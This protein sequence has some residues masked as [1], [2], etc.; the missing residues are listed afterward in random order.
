MATNDKATNNLVDNV[1][2]TILRDMVDVEG[3]KALLE[4]FGQICGTGAG[5]FTPGGLRIGRPAHHHR[6]CDLLYNSKEGKKR[7]RKCD[8]EHIEKI[9]AGE[10]LAEYKCD[11]GLIDFCEPIYSNIGGVQRLIGVFFAGQVLLD[12]TI[13]SSAVD[14]VMKLAVKCEI[15]PAV[16]LAEFMQVPRLSCQRISE[17]RAWMK[18]F[19][20]FIGLLVEKKVATQE[21]LLE[22]IS[23]AKDHNA[24][25]K[26]I[27]EHLKP[28]YVSI[29]LKRDDV[30]DEFAD[31]IFLV[32]TTSEQLASHLPVEEHLDKISYKQKEGLT[33]WVFYTGRV[34]H[35]PNVRDDGC[36]PKDPY[37]PK[38]KHK[39]KEIPD[40][41]ET[42]GFLGAPI[43][44][45]D[46]QVIGVIRVVRLKADPEFKKD[47]IELLTGIASLVGATVSKARLYKQHSEKIKALNQAQGLLETLTVPGTNLDSITKSMVEQLGDI[48][49]KKGKWEAVYV[50]RHLKS[51]KQFQ[52]VACFPANLQDEYKGAPFADTEGVA[53]HVLRTGKSFASSNCRT[54]GVK[55]TTPWVSVICAP[56]IHGDKTWG[57]V[58][59]C[60]RQ[61]RS[62]TDVDLASPKI[63]EFAKDMSLVCR[64][65]EIL[66]AKNT[67]TL[68]ASNVLSLNLEAHE[69]YKSLESSKITVE[70]LC[71]RLYGKERQIAEALAREIDD[72]LSW[73]DVCLELGRYVKLCQES[74]NEAIGIFRSKHLSK[75]DV[76]MKKV[77][78]KSLDS[79]GSLATTYGV[80]IVLDI[81]GSGAISGD[82]NLLYRALRNLLENAIIH[83]SIVKGE[84]I[85]YR[86]EVSVS[87]AV[88]SEDNKTKIVVQDDGEGMDS[89]KL[90]ASKEIY[91]DPTRLGSTSLVPGFGTMIV[92]FAMSAHLGH[93][94]VESAPKRGTRVYIEIPSHK[95]KDN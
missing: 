67:A 49:I 95:Y 28:S 74:P 45:D 65:S 1:D 40:W 9:K 48:Y 86:A 77:A 87:F 7:C 92:A 19:T 12:D 16:L 93:I 25:V 29:F 89:K 60:C 6:F 14:E 5:I 53:G 27:Q 76:D 88:T 18:E 20:K 71:K 66:D 39:I 91:A 63:T 42:L 38:W 54:D 3:V 23:A 85:E 33:G 90:A 22:A 62:Q 36:Y 50:L 78:Q 47:E 24:V 30:P 69:V 79:V 94:T 64:L 57:A 56:I 61:E 55:P 70:N 84:K 13:A 41:Q 59:L 43:R 81:K 58:S 34:L 44:S 46:G 73:A 26:T 35:V 52:F 51:S 32:A 80:E 11:N 17:I 8:D 68:V 75:T 37:P 10:I 21:L 31:R 82:E 72:S 83:G 2:E 4:S 15:N